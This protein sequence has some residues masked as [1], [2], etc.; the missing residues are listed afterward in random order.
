MWNFY[1]KM[2]CVFFLFIRRIL[3]NVC[4][5]MY[6]CMFECITTT[7]SSGPTIVSLFIYLFVY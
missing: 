7:W 5:L 6:V 1:E 4:M 3:V 2:K